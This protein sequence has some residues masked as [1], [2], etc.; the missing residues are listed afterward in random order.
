MTVLAID[1]G[2]SGSRVA[3]RADDGPRHELAGERVSVGADGASVPALVEALLT[4]AAARWPREVAA[5]RGV[6]VGATGLGSL[7]A[8]PAALARTVADRTGAPAA[9]AIDAVTA[10]LGALDGAGGAVVVLGTGAIAVG[11]ADP[12]AGTPWRRVDGWGHLLGDRA[13]GARIGTD[14]LR[15]ALLAHDGVDPSGAGLLAAARERFGDPATWP[16]QLYPRPDRAGVL[17]SFAVDVL[18][19]AA[20]GDPVA[21]RIAADAGTD[22]AHSVVAALPP[23]AP[24]QVCLAGGVARAGGALTAAFG[25]AVAALRPDVVVRPAAGDPL[26]GALAL[27]VRAADGRATTQEGFLW[28]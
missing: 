10:H 9:V 18:G 15:A 27:A 19:A 25:T 7:V 8:D 16:R 21:A 2:G 12:D 23:D 1:V 6:G 20:A 22:A 3:V 4:A 14:G 24:A 28:T 17:A 11:C 5:V 26:D 13:S